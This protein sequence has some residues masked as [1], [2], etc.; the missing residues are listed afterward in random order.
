VLISFE[1]SGVP[2]VTRTKDEAQRL[3]RRVLDDARRGLDFDE[4]VRLYSDDSG[5]K[6]SYAM[7]NWGVPTGQDEVDR[8]KMVR[9]FGGLAFTLQV[10]QIGLVEYDANA[11][12]FGWHIM[13]RLR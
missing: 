2:G 10:G 4:L 13:K 5:G 11:S 3:A 12:P 7:A 1:G 8:R 6:G 9:G